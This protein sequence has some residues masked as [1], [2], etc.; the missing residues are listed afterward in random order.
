MSLTS[1]IFGVL[2][3]AGITLN[4]D[5]IMQALP[6]G[7]DRNTVNTIL[8]QRKRAG[9]L[10]VSLDEGKPHYGIAPGYDHTRRKGTDGAGAKAAPRAKRK[11]AQ[12]VTE[13]RRNFSVAVQRSE[14][15]LKAL[16]FNRDTAR[17]ALDMYLISIA[18]PA[19]YSGLKGAVDAS[20]RALDAWVA[21]GRS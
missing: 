8:G 20:Q 12:G 6:E 5:S 18:D 3:D 2:I 19:I 1:D 13:R 4:L 21:E 15:V 11:Q 7:T 16:Q 9:E 17:D 10:V 14:N